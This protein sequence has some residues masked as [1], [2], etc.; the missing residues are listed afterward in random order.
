ERGPNVSSTP[1]AQLRWLCW[2]TGVVDGS[3][4]RRAALGAKLRRLCV[5]CLALWTG[6]RPGGWSSPPRTAPRGLRCSLRLGRHRRIPLLP[7]RGV[8]LRRRITRWVTLL[9]GI[10]LRRIPGRRITRRWVALRPGG[11]TLRRIPGRRITRR[12]PITHVSPVGHAGAEPHARCH[13]GTCQ[14]DPRALATLRQPLSHTHHRLSL[15]VL[16]V[17]VHVELVHIALLVH[18]V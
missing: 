1:Q 9:W 10:G 7:C 18:E 8:T 11:V 2:P 4:Q 6:R 3:T 5:G 15:G 13:S 17:A 12:V 14:A 16:L